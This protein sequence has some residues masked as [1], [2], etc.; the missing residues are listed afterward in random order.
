MG[1]EI[2]GEFRDACFGEE[3]INGLEVSVKYNLKKG[4]KR[5]IDSI[6]Y[7]KNSNFYYNI[8]NFNFQFFDASLASPKN[9]VHRPK[10]YGILEMT[11]LPMRNVK[12]H[13]KFIA[14]RCW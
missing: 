9:C 11:P 10:N 6:H 1:K 5:N 7:L 4:K 3:K 8:V 2:E 13:A 12:E 14:C